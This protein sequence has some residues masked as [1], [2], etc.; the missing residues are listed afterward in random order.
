MRGQI[1]SFCAKQKRA[2]TEHLTE[3]INEIQQLDTLYILSPTPEIYQR[4]LIL[5]REYNLI[6]TKQAEYL[7]S[8]SRGYAHEHGEK[9]GKLLAHQLR[10]RTANQSIPEI[11]NDQGERCTDT[12]EINKSFLK[13]YQTLHSSSSPQSTS[14][15]EK[16]FQN[17]IIPEL[18]PNVVTSLEEL[19]STTEIMAAIQSMQSRK[20]SGPNGYPSDFYKKFATQLSPI[21][22][23]VLRSLIHHSLYL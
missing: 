7:I 18:D 12:L 4:R 19:I 3:L 6:T 17:S 21:L 10:Q 8:K 9:T 23:S 20:S 2:T 1:I 13:F 11:R 22:K 15:I 16:F 5:Q 14:D